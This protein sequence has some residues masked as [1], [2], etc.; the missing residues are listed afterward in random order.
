MG[1]T[2]AGPDGHSDVTTILPAIEQG[3]PS[4][5]DQLLPLVYDEPRK[6]RLSQLI[7]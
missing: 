1:A 5:P 3:D 6:N 4:A 7:G 2:V